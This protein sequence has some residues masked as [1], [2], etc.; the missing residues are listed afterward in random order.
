[1]DP[2]TQP[3]TVQPPTETP[4]QPVSSYGKRD[5][6]KWVLLYIILG[7]IIYGLLYYF[8]LSKKETNPYT[9]PTIIPKPTLFSPQMK[10]LNPNTGNFY[11]DVKVR[12][13]E[14]LQ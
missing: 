7:V 2:Q 10:N 14:E 9:S 1:M 8:I 11:N 3:A 6:K 5:W 13:K 12:L 4:T